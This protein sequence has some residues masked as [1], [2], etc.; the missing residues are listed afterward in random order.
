MQQSRQ[1]SSALAGMFELKQARHQECQQSLA[2][3]KERSGQELFA[4][5]RKTCKAVLRRAVVRLSMDRARALAM[6]THLKSNVRYRGQEEL[7]R[8]VEGCMQTAAQQEAAQ[9]AHRDRQG[10]LLQGLLEQRRTRKREA[11]VLQGPEEL[12]PW[13]KAILRLMEES[14]RRNAMW[15]HLQQATLANRR[16][17]YQRLM[18]DF[19]ASQDCVDALVEEEQRK[20]TADIADRVLAKRKLKALSCHFRPGSELSPVG[21]LRSPTNS[22][23]PKG[24]F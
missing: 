7:S 4:I 14:Q 24:A 13:K 20:Q 21:S 6:W 23:S 17:A 19:S 3:L 5:R 22:C 16:D 9:K 8:T 10:S 11:A 1:L 15:S 12:L 2:A 18:T